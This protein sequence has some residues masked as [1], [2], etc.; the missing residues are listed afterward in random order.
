[1]IKNKITFFIFSFFLFLSGAFSQLLDANQSLIETTVKQVSLQIPKKT[2]LVIGEMH[3]LDQIKKQ[4]M[5]ILLAL[6]KQSLKISIGFE[7][8]NFTDQ[9]T[10]DDY[11][12][13]LISDDEFKKKINWKGFDFSFYKNQIL[14]PLKSENENTIGLNLPS[15]ITKKIAKD[16]FDS[17][18]SE[19][20]LLLPADFELGNQFYKERFL[21]AAGSHLPADKIDNYFTSQ[22]AWDESMAYQAVKYL[23]QND[24]DDIFVIIVGEFHVQYGGGL[25]DR[26]IQRLKK[27]NLN[28]N[29][30][31]I[32]QI[33]TQDLTS[34]EI[35]FEIKPHLKYGLRADYLWLSPN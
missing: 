5:E 30:K 2:I 18:S 33:S 32:S 27:E 15:D 8:L 26:L 25:P 10:I 35:D 29:V 16:G 23:K 14:F 22:S 11:K 20:R 13:F 19:Q 34:E 4:H 1:M 21:L 12:S 3:G 6:K 17:L 7:F 9:V 31:T 24:T 28:W